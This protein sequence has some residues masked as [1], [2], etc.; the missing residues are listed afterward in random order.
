MKFKKGNEIHWTTNPTKG[1]GKGFT[2]NIGLPHMVEF[3]VRKKKGRFVLRSNDCA[4]PSL[5][6][7]IGLSPAVARSLEDEYYR[8]MKENC[9]TSL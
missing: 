8:N 1:D 3:I 5:I 9:R 6:Y 4:I 7:P 2:K